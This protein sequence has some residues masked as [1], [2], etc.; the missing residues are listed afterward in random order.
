VG[1]VTIASA[2]G[3]P[4]DLRVGA[5]LFLQ[6]PDALVKDTALMRVYPRLPCRS[7]RGAFR[8]CLGFA[9]RGT[10]VPAEPTLARGNLRREHR[11]PF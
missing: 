11:R 2:A 9:W 4:S 8:E 5:R 6:P 3:A 7:A 1:F 10:S